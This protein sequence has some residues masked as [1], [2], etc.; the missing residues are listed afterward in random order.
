MKTEIFNFDLPD[1]LIANKPCEPRD[2]A[3]LLHIDGDHLTDGN[4]MD[5]ANWLRPTDVLVFNDTKVIPA[6]LYGMRGKAQIELTLFKQIDLSTWETL[7]KNARRLHVGDVLTFGQ[8][9]EAIVLDKTELGSVIV[10]F[11]CA[12]EKLFSK[13][14]EVGTMP[15][16][17]DIKR[18]RGGLESDKAD[19]QTM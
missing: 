5:L 17:P 7:I 13:L 14:H 1:E 4:M 8:D 15:L 6:R 16:P 2:A 9:F 3:R 18:L 19:Y 11:N 12:G 10:Q